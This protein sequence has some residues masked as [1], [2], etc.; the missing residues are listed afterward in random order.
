MRD[1]AGRTITYLRLS[2]TNLCNYRCR[3]CMGPDGVEKRP[4]SEI[5]SIEEMAEIGRAAVACGVRKIRL[6]G[7]EPLVRRGIVQL[8]RQLR[9]LPAL[10]ELTLT[11]NASLLPQLAQPLR[12]AGVDRLNISMDTLRPER[13]REITRVG[14]MGQVM[15]G[16]EAARQAG[17]TRTKINVVLLGGFN[18]DE[19]PDFVAL[20]RDEDLSIRFI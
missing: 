5:L 13:F 4:H 11:T 12:E 7:G 6:T 19:I 2:V 3:Y 9:A 8:C 1:T 10:Q 17:F 14:D 15:A 16:L 18:V 20:T